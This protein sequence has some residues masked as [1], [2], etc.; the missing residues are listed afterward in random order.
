MDKSFIKV[1][2]ITIERNKLKVDFIVS[3]I[4]KQYF[5]DSSFWAEYSENI[6]NTPKSIAVIPFLCNVLPIIWV[7]DS[8]LII[9]EVDADF[10]NNIDK[11]KNG[12]IEMYPMLKFGGDIIIERIIE[13][14]QNESENK[15]AACLFSGGIDAFA[16][17][18]A[19]IKEKPLLISV[20][21]ADIKLKDNNSW[22]IAERHIQ[23][24]ANSCNLQT[25]IIVKSNFVEFINQIECNYLVSSTK[26]NYWYG[27][28]HGIG[29]LSLCAPIA[30]LKSLDFVYIAGSFTIKEKGIIPCAS[31]PSIDNNVCYAGTKVCHDQYDKNRQQ[32]ISLISSYC[33]EKKLRIKLRTCYMPNANG[34]NCCTCEKCLRSIYGLLAEGDNYNDYDYHISKKDLNAARRKFL[35]KIPWQSQYVKLMWTDIKNRFIETQ[36]YREDVSVNWIY[37]YDFMHKPT[38][39]DRIYHYYNAIRRRLKF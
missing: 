32:K 5:K 11:I 33:K 24:T 9:D 22:L 17:L 15:K 36:A 20:W 21:G 39:W 12:Y 29:L 35:R 4:L 19:H 23:D 8:N 14:T 10:Y 7:T 27:L 1:S 16:T 34:G 38:I 2:Q 28:Q 3:D 6:S 31:D 26:Y 25:P 13:N 37:D 18:F 30:F